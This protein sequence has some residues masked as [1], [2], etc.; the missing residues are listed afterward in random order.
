MASHREIPVI[1]E[2]EPTS[3]RAFVELMA[4]ERLE[5]T[6]ISHPDTAEPE[7]I[8][9]FRSLAKPYNPGHGPRSFGGHVYAQSAYAASKTVAQGFVIHVRLQQPMLPNETAQL[10]HSRT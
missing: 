7:K 3:P 9:R 4:L 1:D 6:T 8:Q 2:D 5:D 10:T